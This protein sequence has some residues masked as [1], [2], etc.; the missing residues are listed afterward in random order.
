MMSIGVFSSYSL[1]GSVDYYTI[2]NNAPAPIVVDVY[3]GTMFCADHHSPLIPRGETWKFNSGCNFRLVARSS[4][5]SGGYVEQGF[6]PDYTTIYVCYLQY[7]DDHV[8]NR[9]LCF[10][11]KECK[12]K[13]V[14]PGDPVDPPDGQTF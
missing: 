14:N 3:T 2:V 5:L 12:E 8:N 9:K 4:E 11:P 13:F 10:A 7:S 6:A 1:A